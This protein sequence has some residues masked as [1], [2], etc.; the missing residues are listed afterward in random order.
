MVVIALALVPIAA[1]VYAA[2]SAANETNRQVNA[3]LDQYAIYRGYTIRL[4][5]LVPA[6]YPWR[7]TP[8]LSA[9]SLSDNPHYQVSNDF[10]DQRP[11]GPMVFQTTVTTNT[12]PNMNAT[13]G[14]L[15]PYPPRQLYCALLEN[16]KTNAY[17]I[18]LIA[19]HEDLYYAAWVVHELTDPVAAMTSVGCPF[20]Q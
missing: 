17:E 9:A 12:L 4:R 2:F 10:S 19:R 3:L 5:R 16:F 7:F 18:V 20:N 14:A 13:G 8:S 6:K 11:H 1:L 15:L